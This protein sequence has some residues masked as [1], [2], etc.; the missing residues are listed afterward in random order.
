MRYQ[1]QFRNNKEENLVG[2]S[3][4]FEEAV[5]IANYYACKC[6][7]AMIC[8]DTIIIDATTGKIVYYIIG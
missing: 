3:N 8:G 5:G 7:R 6:D 4:S 1:V 2:Q